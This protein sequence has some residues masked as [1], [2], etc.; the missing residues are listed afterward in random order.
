METERERIRRVYLETVA[1]LVNAG[2]SSREARHLAAT[3]IE[4][5]QKNAEKNAK[6]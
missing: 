4:R 3:I 5:A 2:H 1:D 6:R